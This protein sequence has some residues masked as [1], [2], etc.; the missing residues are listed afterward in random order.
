MFKTHKNEEK[1][2]IIKTV[3]PHLRLKKKVY[4]NSKK[5]CPVLELIKRH[6]LMCN[7]TSATAAIQ[8]VTAT[9]TGA[10][11]SKASFSLGIKAKYWEFCLHL[12]ELYYAI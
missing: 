1:Y 4:Q 5:I 11:T 2:N 7:R 10:A 3:I 8:L 9:P 6:D 12:I